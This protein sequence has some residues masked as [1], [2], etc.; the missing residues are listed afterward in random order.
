MRGRL[1]AC[2]AG[3]E[4]GLHGAGLQAVCDLQA[5]RADDN[6]RIPV[7]NGHRCRH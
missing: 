5:V 7:E 2:R 6:G 4:A 1:T 3:K